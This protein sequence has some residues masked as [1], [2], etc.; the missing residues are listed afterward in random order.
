MMLSITDQLWTVI[1]LL[2]VIALTGIMNYVTR[3]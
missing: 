3:P 1:A 2:F